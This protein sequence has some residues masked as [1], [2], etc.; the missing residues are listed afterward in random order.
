MKS[1]GGFPRSDFLT[2][3][4]LAL[5]GVPTNILTPCQLLL[6]VIAIA[7]NGRRIGGAEGEGR[8]LPPT[9]VD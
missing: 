1:V 4:P 9:Y 6:A 5:S 2:P 3:D 8:Y 7:D